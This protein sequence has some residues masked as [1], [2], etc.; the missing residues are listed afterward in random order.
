MNIN[1]K[2]DGELSSSEK[3]D[4]SESSRK[5][6]RVNAKRQRK[7]NRTI[8]KSR[9]AYDKKEKFKTKLSEAESYLKDKKEYNRQKNVISLARQEKFDSSLVGK[10]SN[11]LKS[12]GGGSGVKR[13]PIAKANRS[14]L[15]STGN[16]ATGSMNS[17]VLFGNTNNNVLSGGKIKRR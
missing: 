5:T 11:G 8:A 2:G 16:V 9:K 13:R 17:G 15:F 3:V 1:F 10:F 14:A 7:F 4:L 12:V 6:R